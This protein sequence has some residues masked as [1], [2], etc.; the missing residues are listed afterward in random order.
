MV[1]NTI[2]LFHSTQVAEGIVFRKHTVPGLD[3]L[4]NPSPVPEVLITFPMMALHWKKKKKIPKNLTT[5]GPESSP[6]SAAILNEE[7][8]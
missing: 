2:Y 1:K 6:L 7:L 8:L 4:T 3:V 5:Q